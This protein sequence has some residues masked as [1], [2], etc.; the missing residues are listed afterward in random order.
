MI[1]TL[2]DPEVEDL[3]EQGVLQQNF[4]VSVFFSG[5]KMLMGCVSFSSLL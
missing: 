1:L 3:C 4:G 2:P 5:S